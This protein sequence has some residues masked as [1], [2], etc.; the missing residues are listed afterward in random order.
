MYYELDEASSRCVDIIPSEYILLQLLTHCPLRSSNFKSQTETLAFSMESRRVSPNGS[1]TERE[2]PSPERSGGLPANR[3]HE[4]GS[5]NIDQSHALKRKL[6]ARHLSM[7][8]LGGALGIGLIIGTGPALARG[9]PAA[10][11]IAYTLLGFVGYLVLG[12]LGEI[13]TWLPISSGFTGYASRYVDPAMGFA[14][15]YW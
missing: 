11:L 10:I 13:A 9:G 4:A 14:L 7:I 3:D 15:G 2:K 8:A 6:T 5:V 1:S 12:A